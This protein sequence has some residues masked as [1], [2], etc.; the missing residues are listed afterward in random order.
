M[1]NG[2]YAHLPHYRYGGHRGI[3]IYPRYDIPE[4]PSVPDVNI[5]LPPNYYDYPYGGSPPYVDY[6]FYDSIPPIPRFPRPPP[7]THTN[8]R[9]DFCY[10]F[11]DSDSDDDDDDG[12]SQHLARSKV[13][14]IECAPKKKKKS[15]ENPMVVSTFK[16]R[17]KDHERLQP[18]RLIIPRSTV[19]RHTSLPH[20]GRRK[21]IRLMPL[22][23]SAEPQY[24][25]PRR[26]SPVQEFVPVTTLYST[27]RHKPEMRTIKVRSLSPLVWIIFFKEIFDLKKISIVISLYA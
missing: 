1:Y 11:N 6:S 22:Y 10:Y 21:Q 3:N 23:H 8:V 9:N 19:V 2:M 25:M 15:N 26:R 24:L 12:N 5:F 4:P 20:Y 27:R 18:E 13:Q 7:V 16:Y 14:V 17:E